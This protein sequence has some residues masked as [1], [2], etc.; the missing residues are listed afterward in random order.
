MTLTYLSR[1]G[2]ERCSFDSE[3]PV[4]YRLAIIYLLLPVMIWLLGWF[5]WWLGIP[6]TVLLGLGLWK[7]LSDVWR[8]MLPLVLLLVLL[9]RVIL[10]I[11]GGLFDFNTGEWLGLPA[12][13]LLAFALWKAL[14]GSYWRSSVRPATLVLLVVAAGWVMLT[15]A[16]GAF[17]LNNQ[18]WLDHWTILSDLSRSNWPV[19][20]PTD[21]SDD[22]ALLRYYLG[23]FMVPGLVGHWF[24]PAALD[25]AVPLWTYLGVA[26]ILL[27]FTRN[28]RGWMVILA[29]VVLI[30]FSGMDFLRTILLEG[31]DWI[32]LSVNLNGWP[33]FKLGRDHLEWDKH[34][35]LETQYSSNMTG[36][37]WVPQHFIP[38]ALYTLILVQLR[39]QPRFLA[40]SGV[41]LAA[42]LFWSPFVAI[43]LLPLVA[44]LMIEN[45]P[46][47]FLRWQNLLLAVPLA[48]L[49][50]L[51]LTSGAVDFPHGWLWGKYEWQLLKQWLPIFYLTEF[52]LLACLLLLLRPQLRR[53][54]FFL[55]SLATLLLLP[56]YHYGSFNVLLLRAS[57]PALLLL[58]CYSVGVIA[59]QGM[60]ILRAGRHYRHLAL[61]GLVLVLGVG[62]CTACFEVVRASNNSG[63]F[64]Y[65]EWDT[66]LRDLP[67]KWQRENT[68]HNVPTLLRIL[69][70]NNDDANKA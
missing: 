54:R 22:Q 15:A 64:R 27:L 13:A 43:G 40:V 51:Y 49:L 18:D 17:D 50:T 12:T 9:A 42:S 55:A 23:Y 29:A 36:L 41:V 59:R 68:A 32:E 30:C 37:M 61:V 3:L 19:Y 45:G 44:I 69:L 25:W 70:R 57:L 46:R 24:G 67:L 38:A 53:D 48:G 1:Q 31:W 35:N 63:V 33:W 2:N 5:H 66:T 65:A 62:A 58:C 10:T 4:L 7:A 56:L 8:L 34:Y 47:P 60:D 26:L 52:L 28:Y 39:R 16:G 14:A 11:T 6:V 20:L 21:L